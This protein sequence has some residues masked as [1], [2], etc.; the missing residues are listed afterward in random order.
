MPKRHTKYRVLQG[1]AEIIS[2]ERDPST[3]YY[4]ELLSGTKQYKTKRLQ[5]N[6]IE[7]ATLE[8]VDAYTE[9]R[10]APEPAEP[11]RGDNNRQIDKVIRSY[12]REQQDKV[13][14]G[15]QK[16]TTYDVAELVINK[17]LKQFFKDVGI[18]KTK[19]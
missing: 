8:A 1:K 19:D 12:L 4:R 3:Y 9:L 5:A 7:G 13:R 10:L 16:Q 14:S 6:T 18:K 15:Q 2:Y 17:H 11:S